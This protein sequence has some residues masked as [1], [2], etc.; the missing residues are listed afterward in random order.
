VKVRKEDEKKILR[1]KARARK[2]T[3]K[4]DKKGAK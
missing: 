1:R 2:K 3:E 4:I